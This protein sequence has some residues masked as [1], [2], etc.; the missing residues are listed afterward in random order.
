MATSGY[1]TRVA[2]QYLRVAA[3]G[4]RCIRVY[5]S[6]LYVTVSPTH[7]SSFLRRARDGMGSRYKQ[8]VHLVGV[9]Y[10]GRVLR[11]QLVY[12]LL[13]VEENSRRF[14]KCN[15]SDGSAAVSSIHV[16]FPCA[17]WYEREVWDRRGVVF[18]GNPDLRRILTDYGFSGHPL[19]KDFPLLGYEELRYAESEN[20][21]VSEAVE[22]AQ[23][24]RS[25]EYLS[26]W[27]SSG[28]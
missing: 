8:R 26:P 14:V 7:L 28:R 23:E 22:V 18:Y 17:V 11:F 6:A 2:Q 1:R 27:T 4:V 5:D 21:V 15:L 24:F 3:V 16:L 20:R 12:C 25:Y 19:R 10:P 9:D 13:S